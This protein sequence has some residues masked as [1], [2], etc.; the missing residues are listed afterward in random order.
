MKRMLLRILIVSLLFCTA[1]AIV[2]LINQARTKNILQKNNLVTF[3]ETPSYEDQPSVNFSVGTHAI[4]LPET[5]PTIKL[6]EKIQFELAENKIITVS[7]ESVTSA[8]SHQFVCSGKTENGKNLHSSQFVDFLVEFY[9]FV[10]I[11]M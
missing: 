10:Y 7:V 3:L 5:L 9:L 4:F 11:S 6:G 2:H 8:S 1:T